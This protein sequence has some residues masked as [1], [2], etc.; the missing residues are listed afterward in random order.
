[1]SATSSWATGPKELTF[2]FETTSCIV[3]IATQMMKVS[4]TNFNSSAV[5]HR[6]SAVFHLSACLAVAPSKSEI[7]Q[8]RWDFAIFFYQAA[9]LELHG[10][11][12][13]IISPTCGYLISSVLFDFEHLTQTDFLAK[14]KQILRLS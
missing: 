6:S 13:A 14:L 3:K 11:F 12:L 7:E 10:C 2:E 4:L 1:M 8:H 9:R 5:F